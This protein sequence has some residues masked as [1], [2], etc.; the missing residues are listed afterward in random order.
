MDPKRWDS[1][2]QF[3]LQDRIERYKT[4]AVNYMRV[5]APEGEPCAFPGK[6]AYEGY[7]I[8]AETS[9]NWRNQVTNESLEKAHEFDPVSTVHLVAP[10]ALLLIPAEKDSLIP[11]DAIQEIYE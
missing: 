8:L 6:E 5:V 1:V 9:P 4:G 2:G 3:L 7:R 11:V 10:T